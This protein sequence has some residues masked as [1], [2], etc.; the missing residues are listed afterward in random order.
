MS[1]K[2]SLD[3]FQARTVTP[4]ELLG[5]IGTHM[6]DKTS[7]L[8][9]VPTFQRPYRWEEEQI[10]AFCDDIFSFYTEYRNALAGTGPRPTYFL[11]P[12]MLKPEQNK[13]IILDGQQRLTTISLALIALA[14]KAIKAA[15][16]AA[17]EAMGLA[18]KHHPD[19]ESG[20]LNKE[21]RELLFLARDLWRDYL[22]L[23]QSEGSL[24]PALK[25]N[26]EDD[27]FYRELLSNLQ[28][29]IL[30]AD[31]SNGPGAPNEFQ[32]PQ[33][34]RE[35][36]RLMQS[37]LSTLLSRTQ[38]ILNQLGQE[39]K[40]SYKKFE[41][42]RHELRN[43]SEFLTRG[44]IFIEI[45]AENEVDA[46]RVFETLNDRGL[47]LSSE[48]LI[49]LHLL[50]LAKDEE[51]RQEIVR[52]WERITRSL[53]DNRLK[54]E[55]F[56]RHQRISRKGDIKR[57]PLV[58]EV[59]EVA[60]TL[61]ALEFTRSQLLPDFEL[62]IEINNPSKESFGE[63]FLNLK[64]FIDMGEKRGIALPILLSAARK[65]KPNTA[66]FR[67]LTWELLRLYISYLIL[68]KKDPSQ[69]ESEVFA[70]AAQIQEAEKSAQEVIKKLRENFKIT[71]Q[72]L[73]QAVDK[74][75]RL[76]KS[77]AKVILTLIAEKD[78]KA[79]A[80]NTASLEHII[81]Q[82]GWKTRYTDDLE[83]YIWHLGNL[84]LIEPKLNKSAGSKSFEE[85]VKIYRQSEITMTKEIAQW[86][87]WGR[88]QIIERARK[89]AEKLADILMLPS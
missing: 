48:D 54:T 74:P 52:E 25:L 51:Q 36:H 60:T 29:M 42:L 15:I 41:Y 19:K 1:N 13:T 68:A 11:G 4:H 76:K 45:N 21:S 72:E 14:I 55:D 88:D 78:T 64:R 3:I 47:R 28:K 73:L 38:S 17:K 83:D 33:P 80:L 63:A 37:A 23:D 5:R 84:T 59:K 50:Q 2:A 70:L 30:E 35:S 18:A 67:D 43:L 8:L 22:T 31:E 89:L 65:F 79:E 86:E 81:P 57:K 32:F 62:Y 46:Y 87:Q 49:R 20:K 27:G 53:E 44:L 10:S 39:E 61:G 66:H 7:R 85:K 26:A 82:K 71:K 77:T 75:I 58:K 24:K 69:F 56:L 9:E 16:E 34:R 12:I 40:D 6:P